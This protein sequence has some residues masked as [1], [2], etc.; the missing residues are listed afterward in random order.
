VLW[1]GGNRLRADRIEINREKER[2]QAHGNVVNELL[3]KS[4][5]A[6]TAQKK[7]A[8]VYTVVRAAELL[9]EEET[10]LAHYRGAVL[11]R[12]MGTEVRAQ[13]LRAY[14]NDSDE[15]SSLEKALADGAVEIVQ[16]AS[17][18]TR[19]GIGEH[20]EYYVSDERVILHG[21]QPMLADSVKGTTRGGRLTYF[22][23]NDRLLV[24]GQQQQPAVSRIRRK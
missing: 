3:D 18:R 20:A 19:K 24:D 5:V 9:Y 8:P 14:L 12:R 6:S 15:D 22:A 17:G 21:G 23:N 13:E 10:R 7:S 1:Q 11:L 2:L 16:T 4:K